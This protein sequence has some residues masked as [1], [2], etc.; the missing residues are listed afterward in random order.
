MGETDDESHDPSAAL[1][2]RSEPSG[3][4][5]AALVLRQDADANVPR[6]NAD[7]KG[8]NDRRLTTSDTKIRP[9]NQAL[10]VR[11]SLG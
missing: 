9:L 1:A 4:T 8:E 7:G 6:R 11:S 10:S 2:L 5:T 3:R